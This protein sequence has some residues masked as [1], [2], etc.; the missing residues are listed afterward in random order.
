MSYT[1]RYDQAC[2][3]IEECHRHLFDDIE[4]IADPMERLRIY[5]LIA[6]NTEPDRQICEIRLRGDRRVKRLMRAVR[7]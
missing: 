2:R 4:A 3:L 5:D 6:H 1:P 7:R